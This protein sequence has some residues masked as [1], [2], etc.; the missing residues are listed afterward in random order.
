MLLDRI[1]HFFITVTLQS[2]KPDKNALDQVLVAKSMPLPTSLLTELKKWA[3]MFS[4]E[5]GFSQE[6][7]KSCEA[8]AMVTLSLSLCSPQLILNLTWS[9]S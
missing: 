1:S 4:T 8:F 3:E 6:K 7:I 5:R 2:A 9:T